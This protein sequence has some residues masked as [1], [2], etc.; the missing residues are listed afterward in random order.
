MGAVAV[1]VIAPVLAPRLPTDQ[2]S[3]VLGRVED[4]LELQQSL[5]AS[6]PSR[7]MKWRPISA[8]HR[9]STCVPA[10]AS[11]ASARLSASTGST[12]RPSRPAKIE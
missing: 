10:I 3:T 11:C 5:V 9:T 7:P 8:A 6:R 2:P 12:S 4:L 1:V